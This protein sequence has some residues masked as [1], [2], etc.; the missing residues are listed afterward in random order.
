MASSSNEVLSP[1]NDEAY[2][3]IM[4]QICDLYLA[5][6]HSADKLKFLRDS[7]QEYVTYTSN[8]PIENYIRML[9]DVVKVRQLNDNLS[10]QNLVEIDCTHD[11]SIV[12]IVDY[13][14]DENAA[15]WAPIIPFLKILPRYLRV[16]SLLYARIIIQYL[17]HP[18]ISIKCS[19]LPEEA[20]LVIDMSVI[21]KFV[22][23]KLSDAVVCG[24][25]SQVTSEQTNDSTTRSYVL[26]WW[27][28]FMVTVAFMSSVFVSVWGQ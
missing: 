14:D 24:H 18:I 6:S 16:Y 26:V 22:I 20:A 13:I 10:E 2:E 11:R 4:N 8:L 19:D 15:R 1:E 27:V 3:A 7:F 12:S 9:S 21:R 28:V 17:S 23:N 5:E 25:L